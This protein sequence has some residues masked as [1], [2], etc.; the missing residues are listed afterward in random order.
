MH[1]GDETQESVGPLGLGASPPLLGACTRASKARHP[2]HAADRQVHPCRHLPP[3]LIAGA[4]GGCMRMV[5][6]AF[7][8]D[9]SLLSYSEHKVR[10]TGRR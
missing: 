2:N 7:A 6:R 4:G 9:G 10:S 8:F 1:G 5:P 3:I